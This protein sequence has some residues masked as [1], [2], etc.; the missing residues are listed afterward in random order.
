MLS[1]ASTFTTGEAI[2]TYLQYDAVKSFKPVA[3]LA[4]GP[5]LVTVPAN[6]LTRA[7]RLNSGGECWPQPA[8]HSPSSTDS[9]PRST[10]LSSRHK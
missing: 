8:H 6:P 10:K 1:L 5:L 7:V 3:M 2:R 9:M 4:R